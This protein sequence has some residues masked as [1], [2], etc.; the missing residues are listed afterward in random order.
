MTWLTLQYSPLSPRAKT[1]RNDSRREPATLQRRAVELSSHPWGYYKFRSVFKPLR[2]HLLRS[3]HA[4]WQ[5]TCCGIDLGTTFS[6]VAHLDVTGRPCSLVNSEGDLLAPSVVLFDQSSMVVGKEAVRAVALEPDR[7]A[8][9][10][11]RDMGSTH[12]SK[13]IA[14]KQFPPEVIQAMILEKLRK[15]AEAHLGRFVKSSSR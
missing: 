9:F 13:P 5:R 10:A 12:Y 6:L 3:T 1:N 14:G 2:K 8:E 4:G 11:K 15:D 7:V